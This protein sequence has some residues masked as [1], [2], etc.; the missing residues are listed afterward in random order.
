LLSLT[1]TYT[2]YIYTLSLHDALPISNLL[3]SE[4]ATYLSGRYIEIK[5]FGLSYAEFLAFY[6]FN[7]SSK[8]FQ[9]Y[10]KFG[11]LP[12]LI[13]LEA[14]LQVAY[15]YLTSIYNTIL[16]KDVVTRFKVKIGRA[17]CR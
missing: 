6:Q 16:L 5:V 9:H 17:S 2:T 15:E 4:L 11:G 14:E 12:Y 8:A 13:N 7:D 1:A 3:S 10:L